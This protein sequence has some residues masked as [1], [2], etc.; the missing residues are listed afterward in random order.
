MQPG[1][2]SFRLSLEWSRLFPQ[3]GELDQAAVQRYHDI[4]DTLERCAC[5]LDYL[6]N[7]C[8]PVLPWLDMMGLFNMKLGLAAPISM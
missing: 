7:M 3:R 5:L 2:N 8:C 1:C 6:E 4:F